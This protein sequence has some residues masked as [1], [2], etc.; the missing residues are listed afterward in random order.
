[1][2]QE[3]PLRKKRVFSVD[4]L[5][6][7]VMVIMVLDHIREFVH[8]DA[9]LYSPTDLT[10]TSTTL[11]FTR[12]ITHFCAPVFVFL[13]GTS[14]YL[15]RIN[16]KSP[17]ELS[18]FLVTRGIWLIVVEFTVV[19][20]ALFFNFDYSL[21]GFAEVIWIFGVSM[22]VLAG[23]IFLPLRVIAVIG[24]VVVAGHNLLDGIRI[25]PEISF[26][27]TP[28]P[29]FLQS[30]WMLLH[31]QGMIHFGDLTKVFVAYPLIPWTGVMALGYVVGSLYEMEVEKRRRILLRL[32]IAVTV[33][34]VILRAINIYG[35]PAP[36]A[37]QPSAL[38]TSLSFLN[39]TKYPVSLL[40][41]L[42]TL[43]PAMLLL[44]G[45]DKSHG[46][47]RIARFLM[48]YGRVPLFY[49]ILQMF[50]AHAAGIILGYA[51]GQDAGFLFTNYPF[52]ANVQPSAGFG[53][54]LW[55]VFA[56]WIAGL[57]ILYPLCAWYG[58]LK[59]NNR[60]WAFS[61]L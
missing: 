31:Q 48:T 19:R 24:L 38:F 53:F 16:G 22:I 8:A 37:A 29:D 23:L 12:W 18:R 32:G 51:A 61:Y 4:I 2:S 52:A 14:I 26:A 34:F 30:I 50:Y 5:R 58:K 21:L 42:M 59:R 20:F 44:Y 40:F 15:Q 60:H 27:G 28:P 54:P 39:T 47:G 45:T 11:F 13:A 25:P 55:V 46:N 6:G 10:K 36:W 1:M 33:L 35:D 57:F 3:A 49:F 56:V 17:R 41:L 9:F 43:G 7:L